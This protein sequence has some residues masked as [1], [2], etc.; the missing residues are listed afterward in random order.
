MKGMES[1]LLFVKC[2]RRTWPWGS[3]VCEKGGGYYQ[4][5]QK[6]SNTSIV[7]QC[8][9]LGW[10]T[11]WT[12]RVLMI[13]ESKLSF[14][15][16]VSVQPSWFTSW[17]LR[18]GIFRSCF[19]SISTLHFSVFCGARVFCV[20]QYMFSDWCG[21]D[22]ADT[23]ISSLPR[24]SCCHSFDFFCNCSVT[25]EFIAFIS[26]VLSAVALPDGTR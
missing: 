12:F 14:R 20:N 16:S 19:H 4:H 7:F 5:C 25:G 8:A 2:L 1:G 11:L 3:L 13:K 26:Q 18:A 15:T 6:W 22:W 10:R 23:W 24:R 9:K 17:D 21:M